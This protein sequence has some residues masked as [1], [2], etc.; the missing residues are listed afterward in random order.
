MLQAMALGTTISSTHSTLWC[1]LRLLCLLE[2]LHLRLELVLGLPLLVL[3]GSTTTAL[4]V[5]LIM[6]HSMRCSRLLLWTQA[7]IV[8]F[9]QINVLLLRLL[10]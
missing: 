8:H 10:M 3:G 6:S 9:C 4:G 2:L 7:V 1:V 5:V